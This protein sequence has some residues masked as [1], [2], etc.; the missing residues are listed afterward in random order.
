LRRYIKDIFTGEYRWIEDDTPPTRI[1][2][3]APRKRAFYIIGDIQPYRSPITGE[4]ISSRPA[5]EDHKRRHDVE[6][7]GNERPAPRKP[8]PLP[9]IQQDI[10]EAI[11]KVEAGYKPQQVYPE[12][13]VDPLLAGDFDD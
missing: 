11:E 7:M 10:K 13:G 1:A 5:H 8:E 4:V 6:E 3:P 12:K 2:R 9:P